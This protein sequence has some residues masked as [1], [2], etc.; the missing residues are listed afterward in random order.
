MEVNLDPVTIA[1]GSS[2]A[3]AAGIILRKFYTDWMKGR[4]E[5]AN[6]SAITE[7]FNALRTQL[8]LLQADNK[9]LRDA[10]NA[11][12]VQLHKQQTKLTRTE[13]L[14]RQFV[15]LI[16]QHDIDV[17]VFMQEELDALLAPEL[18]Q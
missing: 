2:G 14:L 4:P 11:M 16:R 13:M 12:D 5:V 9:E 15:G 3:L 1:T 17:P 7:Q 18:K 6:A 8:T 10:F